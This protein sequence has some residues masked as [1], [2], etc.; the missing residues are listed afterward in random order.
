MAKILVTGMS[1]TGKSTV[2]QLLATRGHRTVD[3]DTDEWSRWTTSPDGERDWIWRENVITDLLTAHHEGHLFVAGCKSNQGHFYPLFDEIALLSAPAETILTRIAT[4]TTNPYGKTPDE[5]AAILTNLTT[6]EPL[7]RAT[8]TA[9]I[10]T[11]APL[12]DVAHHLETLA[13]SSPTQTP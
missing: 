7:L 9:E 11:T 4:R 10:N 1:G 6:V 5:R 3:T 12:H 13:N 2:L 8:A